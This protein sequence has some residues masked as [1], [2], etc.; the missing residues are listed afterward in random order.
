[1]AIR[2]N[3]GIRNSIVDSGVVA[4]VNYGILGLYNGTQP[5]TGGGSTSG[6]TRISVINAD[7]PAWAGAVGGTASLTAGTYTGTA[8]STGTISWARLADGGGTSYIIDGNCGTAATCDF[9]IDSAVVTVGATI[10]LSSAN[11]IMPGS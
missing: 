2:L 3:A 8:G 7:V 4:V 11:I 9:V 10:T 1:M 6:C 5:G